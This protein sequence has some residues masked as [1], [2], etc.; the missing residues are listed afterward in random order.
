MSYASATR[1]R[2]T[3]SALTLFFGCREPTRAPTPLSVTSEPAAQTAGGVIMLS[4]EQF[5]RLTLTPSSDTLHPNRWTN[6]AVVVGTDT[7]ESWRVGP[8]QIV[9]R[10]PPVFTGNYVAVIK[11]RGYDEASV[12]FFAVGQAF[13]AYTRLNPYTNV[14]NGAPYSPRGLLIAEDIDWPGFTTGYGLIDVQSQQLQMIP[15]LGRRESTFV[16]MYAPGVTYRANHFVF[17]ISGRG[18]AAATVWRADPWVLVDTI[19]CGVPGGV[20]T[21]V[22]LSA[23]ACLSNSP[24]GGVV[25]NG[26]DTLI[27]STDFLQNATFRLAPGGRWAVLVTVLSARKFFSPVARWSVF[28]Q[29]GN[30]AYAIDTLFHITGAAFSTLGD[31]MYIT[32]SVRDTSAANLAAGRFSLVVLETALPP[33]SCA[34]GRSA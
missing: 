10:V 13:P 22:Q 9:F 16:K 34:S 14:S 17:D 26:V 4:S 24:S 19:P 32:A 20:Y 18:T 12:S 11:A 31:T 21:A 6:F 2:L 5:F 33:R 23:S 15:D 7:A 29:T 28:D 3:L 1:K 30:V 8:T 27:R 25:R